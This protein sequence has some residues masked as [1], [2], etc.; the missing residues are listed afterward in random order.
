VQGETSKLE[1]AHELGKLCQLHNLGVNLIPYIR[2]SKEDKGKCPSMR[3]INEFKEVVLSYSV[4]CSVK[5]SL[6]AKVQDPK[7]QFV[8]QAER[9]NSAK[10]SSVRIKYRDN[11]RSQI[12]FWETLAVVKRESIR[13]R[14][15]SRELK[16]QEGRAV[17]WS[18]DNIMVASFSDGL[19]SFAPVGC[20]MG[21]FGSDVTAEEIAPI[22]Q[23]EDGSLQRSALLVENSAFAF[24][25]STSATESLNQEGDE[26]VDDHYASN[27]EYDFSEEGDFAVEC[28]NESEDT[29]TYVS[30]PTSTSRIIV[31]KTENAPSGDGVAKAAVVGGAVAALSIVSVATKDTPGED[32]S[33]PASRKY[34]IQENGEESASDIVPKAD[35]NDVSQVATESREGSD[36]GASTAITGGVVGVAS[37]TML[38][39]EGGG[40]GENCGSG[41]ISIPGCVDE[42]SQSNVKEIVHDEEVSQLKLE[43]HK[44]GSGVAAAVIAGRVVGTSLLAALASKSSDKEDYSAAE[45]ADTSLQ[46]STEEASISVI[47]TVDTDDALQKG[48]GSDRQTPAHD[49][50]TQATLELIGTVLKSEINDDDDFELSAELMDEIQSAGGDDFTFSLAIV[51]HSTNLDMLAMQQTMMAHIENTESEDD[52]EDPFCLYTIDEHDI[53]DDNSEYAKTGTHSGKRALASNEKVSIPDPNFDSATLKDESNEVNEGAPKESN[54]LLPSGTLEERLQEAESARAELDTSNRFLLSQMEQIALQANEELTAQIEQSEA[55]RQQ[56][57]EAQTLQRR[58]EAE[59]EEL[60]KK[61]SELQLNDDSELL[62]E[63]DELRERLSVLQFEHNELRAENMRLD[64]GHTN[65][66]SRSLQSKDNGAPQKSLADALEEIKNVQQENAR[67]L[68]ESDERSYEKEEELLEILRE[69]DQMQKAFREAA[70]SLILKEERLASALAETRRMEQENAELA[71]DNSPQSL[72]KDEELLEIMWK[73]NDDLQKALGEAIA[74]INEKEEEIERF[75]ASME[76]ILHRRMHE[77][78]ALEKAPKEAAQAVHKKEEKLAELATL[79]KERASENEEEVESLLLKNLALEQ[80]LAAAYRF[81]AP[82]FEPTE[83]LSEQIEY[84]EARISEFEVANAFLETNIKQLQSSLSISKALTKNLSSEEVQKFDMQTMQ[85]QNDELR[86]LCE[87]LEREKTEIVAAAAK[88]EA[89]ASEK[90][91]LVADMATAHLTGRLGLEARLQACEKV[92]HEI[93]LDNEFMTARMEVVDLTSVTEIQSLKAQVQHIRLMLTDARNQQT[94]AEEENIMLELEQV[95]SDSESIASSRVS[96]IE[97]EDSSRGSSFH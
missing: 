56:M 28:K 96:D 55:F 46:E 16:S 67:L 71:L 32:D 65:G 33:T 49:P 62:K 30:A 72:G 68:R 83:Q 29:L 45:S 25:P 76:E 78:I 79:A 7:K 11:S 19:V 24:S 59:R 9:S 37:I 75:E 77:K 35:A 81:T 27:V 12:D 58:A 17:N 4:V 91:R 44:L 88:E 1:H 36:S 94:R 39:S 13:K 6:G 3:H 86:A 93:T 47:A 21:M 15:K 52:I 85:E 69:R 41:D 95:M 66:L 18:E 38:R 8:V 54:G 2:R 20:S 87:K 5:L 92:R 64:N 90:C 42:K 31:A 89:S 53:E 63:R 34:E 80:H 70:K 97:F 61:V 26:S 57:L 74:C 84:L 50:V 51:D 82:S 73:E 43:R 22:V 48:R 14:R 40:E 60:K 10:A 23:M